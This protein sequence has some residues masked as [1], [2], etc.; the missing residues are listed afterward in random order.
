MERFTKVGEGV[1]EE[2][3]QMNEEEEGEMYG[4][5]EDLETGEVSTA[6][7]GM[8]E[9]DTDEENKKITAE[10]MAKEADENRKKKAEL[11]AKFDQEYDEGEEKDY[12]TQMKEQLDKEAE[13]V[14][15]EFEG[16]DEETRI[17]FEGFRVGRY[18]RIEI[19]GIPAEY[20]KYFNPSNPII[21]GGLLPNE[22]QLALVQVNNR[23]MKSLSK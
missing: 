15:K 23:I 21:V 4:D 18:V 7:D 17:Q 13:A 1:P 14:R 3:K 2:V 22:E 5:F 19:E 10:L 12:F 16:M 11:K 9:E 6:K 20:I 8:E